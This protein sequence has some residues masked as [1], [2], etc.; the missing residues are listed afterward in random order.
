MPDVTSA[1]GYRN[2]GLTQ[3]RA[4]GT[5]RDMSPAII[6]E[7]P[8]SIEYG[9]IAYAVM[10]VT[11]VDLDDFV[12]GFSLSEQVIAAPA[13]LLSL[14]IARVERGWVA[15][16]ALAPERMERVLDRAR[17]RVSEGSCGLCGL[18]NL[19]Q[20]MRPLP[21]LDR[22]PVGDADAVFAALAALRDQQA[23]GRAT[24]A[25]HAAAFCDGRG[26]IVTVRED[27]GRH[28][29]L[30]KLVG[31]LARS[32][33]DPATGFFLLSA[34]CSYELVEK[35]LLAGCPM[36]VTISAASG[37]AIERA[38]A[39]GLTLVSLARSDAVLIA[40]DPHGAMRLRSSHV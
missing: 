3:V 9:G 18:E 21:R 4:D 38:V 13:E 23:L 5:S 37:L 35:T 22:R 15:R 32:G 20:V 26:H 29:A 31:A 1:R 8:L 7:V 11:P 34:R 2:V 24:G 25:A 33:T 28:N 12:L 30:D 16:A 17:Q 36:L 14:E 39:H 6:D 10:M 27:V 40:H 19:E